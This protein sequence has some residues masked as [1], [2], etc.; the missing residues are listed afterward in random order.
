MNDPEALAILDEYAE[1]L[2]SIRP[3][4]G[5]AIRVLLIAYREWADGATEDGLETR[6]S[7]VIEALR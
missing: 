4:D 6:L 3:G 2:R 1:M 7:R 5:V